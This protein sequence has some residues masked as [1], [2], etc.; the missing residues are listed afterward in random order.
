MG[1]NFDMKENDFLNF[2][3]Q[4]TPAHPQVPVNI[5]DDMAI[6]NLLGSGAGVGL[7]GG[8][9][10]KIDQ[11][12]DGVH[13]DLRHHSWEQAGQ[14]A[15]NRCLSDCAAMAC[16]PVAIML[17]VVLPHEATVEQARTLFLACRDAAHKFACPLVGG[18]T[19]IWPEPGQRLAITV[20]ALGQ[21]VPAIVPVR[22]STAQPGDAILVTGELGGSILGR[23]LSFT[24]RIELAL[25]LARRVRLTA[26]M[27][28]S[29]GLAQ[30]LPRLCRAS[31]VGALVC[32]AQLPVHPD[33]L[34]LSQRDGLPPA[35]H[36]LA[37]GEDYELLFTIP[38]ADLPKLFPAPG[39][40]RIAG[41]RVTRIGTMTV[42][43]EPNQPPVLELLDAEDQHHPWPRGGWEH[44]GS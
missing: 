26:M 20:S 44:S 28:L 3:A 31:N 2:I 36:A 34:K 43:S 29:D 32:P 7:E 30:D 11:S 18:D 37:D 25:E 27:D 10:L 17:A 23:H 4:H 39:S 14:K 19:S 22:R 9:L 12:L 5:G 1:Y 40:N 38:E 33:A 42:A 24:P 8:A 16:R 15:V 35:L 13:F 21:A 6:V 41:V